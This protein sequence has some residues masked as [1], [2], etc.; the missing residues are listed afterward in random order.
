MMFD[1]ALLNRWKSCLGVQVVPKP[2][3]IAEYFP[4]ERPP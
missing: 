3:F 2:G 4:M 1:L